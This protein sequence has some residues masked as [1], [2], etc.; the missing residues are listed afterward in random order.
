MRAVVFVPAIGRSAALTPRPRPVSQARAIIV[1]LMRSRR[2]T[3]LS[4]LP[5]VLGPR[6]SVLGP[7]LVLGALSSRH[8]AIALSADSGQRTTT[9]LPD[10]PRTEDL[11]P[12]TKRSSGTR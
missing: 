8:A 10:G 9:V 5:L 11:A 6:A 12:R 7:S 1:D 2:F 4:G 3:W